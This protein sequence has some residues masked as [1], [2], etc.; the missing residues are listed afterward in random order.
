M[1]GKELE[2]EAAA[3]NKRI[4][5]RMNAGFIPDLQMKQKC[6]YFYQSP[7]RD[8]YYSNIAYGSGFKEMVSLINTYCPKTRKILDIGCGPGTFSLELARLGYDVT[9]LDIS[10]QSIQLAK[11]TLAKTTKD[12]KFGSLKYFVSSI[13]KFQG[14]PFDLIFCRGVLHH[15]HNG[16][17]SELA[18]CSRLLNENGFFV[19]SEPTSENLK[20]EDIKVISLIRGL[21]ALTGSWYDKEISKMVDSPEH[22]K[23]FFN[24]VL[25][26]YTS[27][28]DR[29]EKEGQSPND[30]SSSGKIIFDAL[31]EEFTQ[32]YYK[33]DLNIV[34]RLLGGLRGSD[35]ICYPIAAFLYAWQNE[36]KRN[37]SAG[38]NVFYFVGK[39]KPS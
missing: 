5:E 30:I 39:K 31:K 12:R 6:D 11:Q 29:H 23:A 33:P 7:F 18:C 15:L 32:I 17:K 34:Y 10:E 3:F 36:Y 1:A 21:L 38:S 16:G 13:E 25:I 22:L 24:S 37:A 14:G 4:L 27:E 8:S 9:A 35:D 26:E 2:N 19:C 28:T 20:E